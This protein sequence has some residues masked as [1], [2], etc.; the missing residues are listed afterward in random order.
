MFWRKKDS[1]NLTKIREILEFLTESQATQI[2]LKE[3]KEV[4]ASILSLGKDE[5][6]ISKEDINNKLANSDSIWEEDALN[7]IEREFL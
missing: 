3:P 7:D 2:E 5:D 4:L 6:E 1:D